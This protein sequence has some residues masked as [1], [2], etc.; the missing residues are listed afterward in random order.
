MRTI[1]PKCTNENSF[2][3][4]ILISL[5]YYELNNHPERITQLKKYISKYNFESNNYKDFENNNP[6]ISINV[7]DEYGELLHK[8]NNK[9]NNIVKLVKRNK[10]RYNALK[11]KKDKCK[12]LDDLLKQFT[13]KELKRYILNKIIQV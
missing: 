6:S 13:H 3:Y 2:K 1:N 5:H 7:Y 11:P 12:K 9:T 4:S 10:H 8:S